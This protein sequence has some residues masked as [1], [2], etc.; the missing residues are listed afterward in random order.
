MKSWSFRMMRCVWLCSPDSSTLQL[1]SLA[2]LQ[3]G[4][5]QRQMAKEKE[6]LRVL[7]E[8]FDSTQMDRYE[9]YRRSGLTKGNVR[10]VSSCSAEG[11]SSVARLAHPSSPF[12]ARESAPGPICFSRRY[13]RRARFLQGLCG[14]DCRERCTESF[15][16]PFPP[17]P[18]ILALLCSPRCRQSLWPPHSCR[19]ARGLPTLPSRARGS[20]RRRNRSQEDVCQV[21]WGG[22]QR[23]LQVLL[24]LRRNELSC[25]CCAAPDLLEPLRSARG[26]FPFADPARARPSVGFTIPLARRR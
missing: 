14:R 12:A 2:R 7:L 16:P 19:P 10:K 3:F 1:T 18:L 25:H 26:C 22:G 9:A 24:P 8:H 13:H 21:G 23:G 17:S 11:L 15:A 4:M 5:N 6:D 20:R